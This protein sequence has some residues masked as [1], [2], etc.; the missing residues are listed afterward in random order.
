MNADIWLPILS[1]CISVGVPLAIFVARNWLVDWISHSV[2]H[3]FNVE[4]IVRGVEGTGV[5]FHRMHA[6]SSNGDL[7]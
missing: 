7:S 4:S 1:I 3:R 2:E 5:G 6:K